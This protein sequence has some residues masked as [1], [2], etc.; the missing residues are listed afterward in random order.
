M[1]DTYCPPP[2]SSDYLQ[3]GVEYP[4]PE[5]KEWIKSRDSAHN[6]INYDDEKSTKEQRSLG[7][8]Q[9]NA[10][11]DKA[12]KVQARIQ[13]E[14]NNR[15]SKSASSLRLAGGRYVKSPRAVYATQSNKVRKAVNE[16]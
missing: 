5:G 11:K 10:T 8:V 14:F 6:D 2:D 7:G 3:N 9:E 13:S 12:L 15:T 16:I 1:S 4:V